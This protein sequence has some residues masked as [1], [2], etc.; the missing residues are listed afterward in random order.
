MPVVML[1]GYVAVRAAVLS[2]T[3]DEAYT[4]LGY[5]AG[6]WGDILANRPPSA[7][8]HVLSTLL[9]KVSSG[10][11]GPGHLALRLPSLLAFAGYLLGALWLAWWRRSWVVGLAGFVLLCANPYVLDFFSL[12][13]GYGLGLA[14]LLASLVFLMRFWDR[15]RPQ[16]LGL[17]AALGAAAVLANYVMLYCY[18][19]LVLVAGGRLAVSSWWG[20]T[21]PRRASRAALAALVVP[22]ALLGV[23]VATPI[24]RLASEGQLYFGGADG[25]WRDT[26]GS[27]V[28]ASSYG[29]IESPFA[30]AAVGASIAGLIAVAAVS[31]AGG[32][33]RIARP[34]EDPATPVLLVLLLTS[35]TISAHHHVLGAPA[36]MGRTGLFLCP[37]AATALV[38]WADGFEDVRWRRTG[39]AVAAAV[40][41]ALTVAAIAAANLT[42]TLDWRS[43]ADT[44]RMLADLRREAVPPPRPGPVLLGVHWTLEPAINFYR[45]TGHLDWLAPVGRSGYLASPD[46]LYGREEDLRGR[47]AGGGRIVG[48]YPVAGTVLIATR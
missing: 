8:N 15:G 21:V 29:R 33:K 1:L 32:W 9:V 28:R 31:V 7:N 46:F 19:A 44:R 47:E 38:L 2:V 35:L 36:P 26:V 16:D 30:T 11:L 22:V 45:I 41:V 5:V 24:S 37:L 23:L 43:D 42:H 25:L 39:A 10:W 12:A 3:H 14:A 34:A 20:A 13:R 6:P 17:M 27:L 18:V 40:A 48:R 4:Y